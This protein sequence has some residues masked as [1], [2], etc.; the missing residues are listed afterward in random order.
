[1][2]SI[3]VFFQEQSQKELS[4]RKREIEY[5]EGEGKNPGGGQ[6]WV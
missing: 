6:W 2:Y 5:V 3:E 4:K 1:M